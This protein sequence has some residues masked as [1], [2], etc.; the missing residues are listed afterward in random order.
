[1]WRFSASIRLSSSVATGDPEG[2][3]TSCIGFRAGLIAFSSASTFGNQWLLRSTGAIAVCGGKRPTPVF[4]SGTPKLKLSV[5]PRRS[6]IDGVD[7]RLDGLVARNTSHALDQINGYR[8]R[9]TL[10]RG[11]PIVPRPGQGG[12]VFILAACT[13]RAIDQAFEYKGAAPQSYWKWLE[14]S[15][16]HKRADLVATATPCSD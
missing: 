13:S 10:K 15:S 6:S 2:G 16:Q 8:K 4:S 3:N 7:D 11:R 5:G 12:R 9:D 1:M 14:R